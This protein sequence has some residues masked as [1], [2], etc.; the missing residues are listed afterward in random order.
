MIHAIVGDFDAPD[1]GIRSDA[2][3]I[4]LGF[5]DAAALNAFCMASE[6]AARQIIRMLQVPVAAPR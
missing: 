6:Q 2:L 4:L 3:A 5:I 1:E